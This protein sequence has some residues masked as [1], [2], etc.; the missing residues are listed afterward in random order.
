[1]RIKRTYLMIIMLLACSTGMAQVFTFSPIAS[2]TGATMTS[3][4]MINSGKGTCITSSTGIA[5]L[6][7][8]TNGKGEF[9]AGCK[10]VAP[11]ATVVDFSVSLNVYPNP[12]SGMTTI[13]C[14]GQFDANLSCQ[15][16]ILGM[17][18]R[19]MMSQMVAMKDV[20]AG[21]TVNVAAYAA[22]TYAVVIDFMSQRYSKKLIK[23]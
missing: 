12:T 2:S 4:P 22:G 17:D 23:I 5:A 19:T 3:S 14:D 21:Y 18:G 15:I 8:A 7:I 1:M 16:R 10:E 11:V 9:G 6:R 13:K 20:K